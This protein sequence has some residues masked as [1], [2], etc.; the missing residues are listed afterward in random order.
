MERLNCPYFTMKTAPPPIVNL[1]SIHQIPSQ[2]AGS[3]KMSCYRLEKSSSRMMRIVVN[4]VLAPMRIS[5]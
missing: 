5:V 3:V 4:K 2:N 1:M